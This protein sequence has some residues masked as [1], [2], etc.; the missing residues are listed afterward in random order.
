VTSKIV[1]SRAEPLGHRDFIHDLKPSWGFEIPSYY[2]YPPRVSL[3]LP[4]PCADEVPSQRLPQPLQ[5]YTVASPP[6]PRT[7]M[8]APSA[9]MDDAASAAAAMVIAT[10]TLRSS[11]A[12]GLDNWQDSVDGDEGDSS[13]GAAS[14][15]RTLR[16]RT[17]ASGS[18][19]PLQP[20][21]RA[22]FFSRGRSRHAA[23]KQLFLDRARAYGMSIDECI[24]KGME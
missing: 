24:V 3:L 6:P 23:K 4:R 17:G 18:Q 10:T 19:P 5:D 9:S 20:T 14:V 7:T 15:S 21:L 12:S 22:A 16:G 11:S 8:T 2:D 13:S 1:V